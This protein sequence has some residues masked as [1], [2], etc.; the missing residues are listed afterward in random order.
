MVWLGLERKQVLWAD[1]IGA[2]V[3]ICIHQNAMLYE[4]ILIP[5]IVYA[6][7]RVFKKLLYFYLL[8]VSL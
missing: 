8:W 4:S 3:V 6:D 2:L 1:T 5:V 7:V